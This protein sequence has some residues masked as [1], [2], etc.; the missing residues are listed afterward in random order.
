MTTANKITMVRVAMIPVFLVLC[1][2]P[3]PHHYLASVIVFAIASIT[4][5]IDG[6]IARKYNQVT[7]FG[8]F[9][10]PLAD[11]LLVISALLVFT[12]VGFMHSVCTFII[13][14]RE[15]IITSLRIL[16]MGE[17]VVMAAGF[18]G[19]VK[20]FSQMVLIILSFLVADFFPANANLLVN[21]FSYIMAAITLWSGI[22]Y[23]W[24]HRALIMKTK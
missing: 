8:K 21:I 15:L 14:G 7:T 23:L 11:K 12:Q 18:S 16:A 3:F 9:V 22:D 4:D 10:D 17:G 1:L 19:K 5:F 20:T 13:I 2:W 6:Y 24:R